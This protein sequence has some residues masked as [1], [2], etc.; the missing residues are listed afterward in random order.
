MHANLDI[1]NQI[2]SKGKKKEMS[3]KATKISN[4]KNSMSVTKQERAE[5][6]RSTRLTHKGLRKSEKR[7]TTSTSTRRS[8]NKG[9]ELSS[10]EDSDY[11][12]SDPPSSSSTSLPDPSYLS[13]DNDDSSILSESSSSE[14]SN[15]AFVY[16]RGHKKPKK[17]LTRRKRYKI[18]KQIPGMNNPMYPP[19][20]SPLR[21]RHWISRG[22][23]AASSDRRINRRSK[24]DQGVKWNGT[25]TT[26]PRYENGLNWRMIK[27]RLAGTIYWRELHHYHGN[28]TRA[29]TI[30]CQ[31]NLTGANAGSPH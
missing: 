17:G 24:L 12:P 9:M 6:M 30:S 16:H 20:P 25:D 18:P 11:V 15:D 31:V 7:T 14:S 28:I 29:L 5:K 3:K 2:R 8:H 22:L 27:I 10:D 1:Y 21:G 19:N 26:F 23:R 13:N 4:K